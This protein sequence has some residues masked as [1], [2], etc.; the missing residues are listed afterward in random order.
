MNRVY[1]AAAV[2]AVSFWASVA[3]AVSNPDAVAVIIGNRN[4]EGRV[5]NVDYAHR[6]ADAIRGYVVDVLGYD[7]DNVIDLR[8]ATKAQLETTFGNDRSHKGILWRYIDPSGGSDVTVFYSGHGVPGQR[9]GRGYL[10]PANANPDTAELNGYPIDLLYENLGKLEVRSITVMLDA[11]FSGDSPQG[12]L[13]RS[14][15]PVFVKSEMPQTTSGMTVLTAATGSQLASWDDE[16]QHGLFT[17]H[18]L[19]A[20]YGAGDEDDDGTVTAGEVKKYLDRKMTRAARREFGREQEA[21]FTGDS[22]LVL[23]AATGGKFPERSAPSGSATVA[24]EIALEVQDMTMFVGAQRVNVRSGPGTKFE[25]VGVLEA[26]TEVAVTAKVRNRNWYQIALAGGGQGFVFGDLLTDR[27][28]RGATPAVGTFQ[29]TQ[30]P[31]ETFRDCPHCPEMVV[32]GAG[33]YAMGSPISE[34]Q[35]QDDEGPVHQVTIARPFAI[36]KFEVTMNEFS[37]FVNT[38]GYN[39]D[40]PCN[41]W[42]NDQWETQTGVTWRSPGYPVGGDKPVVCVSYNDAR[43]YTEWLTVQTGNRYRLPSEAEWEYATR[44]GTTTIRYWGDDVNAGCAYAN[45]S[46]MTAKDANPHWTTTTCRDGSLHT[47]PVGSYQPNAFGLYDTLG[48]VWEWTEDCKHANYAGAPADGSAWTVGGDCNARVVRGG[49]WYV[50]P[51]TTRS[52]NRATYSKKHRYDVG[53]RVAMDLD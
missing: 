11:C 27:A 49:S 26:G 51:P 18:L 42:A 25:K 21:T 50:T 37:A 8:D 40:G 28:P 53:F 46:D 31:G 38:T 48:N 1:V 19:D 30:R 7:P 9:D 10:L 3:H 22:N 44:A 12:M 39:P 29:Q 34:T 47:A 36:G 17:R 5:P 23:A 41:V 52:A 32:L 35:R 16:A 20:V 4:Y 2:L 24:P 15:S 43:A 6:D 33:S 14:A 13:I 45:V